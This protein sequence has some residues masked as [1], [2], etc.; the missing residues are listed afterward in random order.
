MCWWKSGGGSCED[1]A[2][3]SVTPQ[4]SAHVLMHNPS[5]CLNQQRLWLVSKKTGTYLARDSGPLSVGFWACSMCPVPTWLWV[6]EAVDRLGALTEFSGLWFTVRPMSVDC[7]EWTWWQ[8]GY[9][10][11]GCH[12]RYLSRMP[13][14]FHKSLKRSLELL[15]TWVCLRQSRTH[16]YV[17]FSGLGA[18]SWTELLKTACS[19]NAVSPLVGPNVKWPRVSALQRRHWFTERCSPVRQGNRAW[20]GRLTQARETR[21]LRWTQGPIQLIILPNSETF[22][23][24]RSIGF[25]LYLFVVWSLLYLYS[26]GDNDKVGADNWMTNTLI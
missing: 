21:C 18:M 22:S 5:A 8:C 7:R 26:Y 6:G 11:G 4:S 15:L 20:S 19:A 23:Q 16:S 10:L 14:T 17:D 12:R 24:C 1:G 25:C 3:S 2:G 9:L 13:P